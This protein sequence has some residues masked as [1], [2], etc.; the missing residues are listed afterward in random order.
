MKSR[1][2]LEI[3]LNYLYSLLKE[4]EEYNKTG[5]WHVDCA[6]IDCKNIE[7]YLELSK[8]QKFVAIFFEWKNEDCLPLFFHT[9]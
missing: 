4:Q 2:L 5:R 8:W 9:S 6:C 7:R 1:K 3:R